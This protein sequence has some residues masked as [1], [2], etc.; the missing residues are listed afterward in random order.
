MKHFENQK[1][2]EHQEADQRCHGN[3]TLLKEYN[4]KGFN[5]Y[6]Q[7][8][9]ISRWIEEILR[10]GD[11]LNDDRLGD[12][13]LREIEKGT[14]EYRAVSDDDG[15]YNKFKRALEFKGAEIIRI[16]ENLHSENVQEEG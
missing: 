9:V 14:E 5:S 7:G 11:I 8:N 1:F 13:I 6:Y 4:F 10:E 12:L 3:H 15:Q 16:S 2:K